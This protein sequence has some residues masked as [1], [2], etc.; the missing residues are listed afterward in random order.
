MHELEWNTDPLSWRD[1]CSVC[2]QPLRVQGDGGIVVWTDS[3]HYHVWCLLDGLARLAF[4]NPLP[5]RAAA[6]SA[7]HWGPMP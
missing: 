1:K 4:G 3:K 5:Q 2:Q 6:D 7:S